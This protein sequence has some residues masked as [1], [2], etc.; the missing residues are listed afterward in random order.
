MGV[1]IGNLIGPI[2]FGA[3]IQSTG[4]YTASFAMAPVIAL[5]A[6]LIVLVPSAM[7][8]RARE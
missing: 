1:D 5:A 8:R 4:S 3:V 2:L 6:S 7:G